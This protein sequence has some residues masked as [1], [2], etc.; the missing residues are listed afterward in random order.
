VAVAVAGSLLVLGCGGGQPSPQTGL[1]DGFRSY[2]A[3]S[4]GFAIGLA[5]GWHHEVDDA[6]GVTFT[7]PRSQNLLLVHFA[8][9]PSRDLEAATSQMM[10]ELTGS[11]SHAYTTGADTVL[12]GL[13]AR[14]AAADVSDKGGTEHIDAIVT[15]EGELAWAVALAG[16]QTAVSNAERDFDRM[17]QTFSLRGTPP[18]PPV[19]VSLDAPAPD[20]PVL[21][22]QTVKG[23][24]VLNF[25]ATWCVPCRQE[26]PMLQGREKASAGQF[27]VLGVDT[28]DQPNKVPDFL[29]PL[30]VTFPVRYD[31][32]SKLYVTYQLEGVPATFFLDG[33]HVVR[34]SQ[35]GPLNPAALDRGLAAI[36]AGA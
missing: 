20:S 21:R 17:S 19:R 29:Q 6:N 35:L 30:G 34:Y 13:P 14:R 28:Q 12:A 15:V 22:L 33:T 18:S 16:L 7:G 1:P 10:T 23:P 11:G 36:S 32:D 31:R 27:S 24:I 26:L 25:F 8:R 3:H 9:A 5:P 2:Q 4:M